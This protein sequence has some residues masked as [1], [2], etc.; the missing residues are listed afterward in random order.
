[1]FLCQ[2]LLLC[3]SMQVKEVWYHEGSQELLELRRWI[4]DYSLPRCVHLFVFMCM[5][6][7]MM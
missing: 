5:N 2:S 1:M 4:A 6:I 7:L 3:V